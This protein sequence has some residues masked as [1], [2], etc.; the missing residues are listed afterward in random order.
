MKCC[1]IEQV[2]QNIPS[3]MKSND[4]LRQNTATYTITSILVWLLC[5]IFYV[6]LLRRSK[7]FHFISRIKAF[8]MLY[9]KIH[10]ESLFRSFFSKTKRNVERLEKEGIPTYSLLTGFLFTT[11]T[12]FHTL[13][14]YQKLHRP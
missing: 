8:G 2:M 14:Y 6:A 7:S 9:I 12:K 10:L 11:N 13:V 3:E 5:C 4:L 1:A